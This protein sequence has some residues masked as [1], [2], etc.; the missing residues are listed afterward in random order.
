MTKEDLVALMTIDLSNEVRHM[1][2][3]LRA[4]TEVEGLHREELREFFMKE[5]HEEMDHVHEFSDM[6][7]YLGGE[8]SVGYSTYV[9]WKFGHD[10]RQ[11]IAEAVRME[12][13]VAANYAK[14]LQ[15]TEAPHYDVNSFTNSDYDPAIAACH[16]F[17]EDQIKNSQIAAWE[18][19]KWLTKF[20]IVAHIQ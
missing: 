3:Y 5:A 6:I 20:P 8:V 1:S 16:V 10:P 17:Y 12:N 15:Q 13:E 4:A 18:M 19:S 2:F 9:D 7:S 14:R 11:I